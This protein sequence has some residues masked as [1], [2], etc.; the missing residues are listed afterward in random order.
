[1][2][3][4]VFCLGIVLCFFAAHLL[5]FRKYKVIG[6]I[7][8]VIGV[9]LLSAATLVVA[10]TFF[11][12]PKVN[13]TYEEIDGVMPFHKFS[14][15]TKDIQFIERVVRTKSGYDALHVH[16]KSRSDVVRIP[17]VGESSREKY[18]EVL[19]KVGAT[20]GFALKM[21]EISKS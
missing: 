13:V 21:R 7:P 15:P 16:L 8:G 19:T 10:G 5:L 17:M 20:R 9:V 4:R 11:Y 2:S 6:T 3:D 1:M 14:I 12:I 18:F